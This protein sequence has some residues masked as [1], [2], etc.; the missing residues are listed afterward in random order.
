MYI[1]NSKE[2]NMICFGN[3]MVDATVV[4]TAATL[5]E[6]YGGLS[7]GAETRNF[8]YAFRKRVA[9]SKRA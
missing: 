7:P 3:P 8:D 1:F 9:G 4:V 6:K 2:F 5:C